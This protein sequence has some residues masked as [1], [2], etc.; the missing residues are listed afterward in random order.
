MD[1][2]G[3]RVLIVGGPNSNLVAL[4]DTLSK[5]GFTPQ[6]I[7]QEMADKLSGTRSTE[8]KKLESVYPLT[9]IYNPPTLT[10]RERRMRE[11]KN[12]KR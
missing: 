3:K 4:V 12:K 9:H 7:S 10:R 6:V 1:M 11:R 2:T 5:Q 8:V